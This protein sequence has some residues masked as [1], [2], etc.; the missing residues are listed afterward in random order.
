MPISALGLLCRGAGNAAL[1]SRAGAYALAG[2]GAG[3]WEAAA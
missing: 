2:A 1:S 3:P